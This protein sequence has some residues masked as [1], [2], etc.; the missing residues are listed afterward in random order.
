MTPDEGECEEDADDEEDE[1]DV[2]D[3]EDDDEDDSLLLKL[4]TDVGDGTSS[5]V[6][7]EAGESATL[8]LAL[9]VVD[10]PTSCA[11]LT[12]EDERLLITVVARSVKGQLVK[13]SGTR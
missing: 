7:A 12:G 8:P 6:V 2:V 10:L 11:R 3:E 5:A 13:L 4:T 9:D 1:E